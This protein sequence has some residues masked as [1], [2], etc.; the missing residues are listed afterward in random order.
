MPAKVA[1][2]FLYPV[3]EAPQD[4]TAAAGRRKQRGGL[5]LDNINVLGFGHRWVAS[6][7]QL[8]YLTGSNGIGGVRHVLQQRQ[9]AQA[10]HQLKRPGVYEV[11]H[12]HTGCIAKFGVGGGTAPAQ[13]GE[14]HDVV[15]QQRGGMDEFNHGCE[16]D[17]VRAD[18]IEGTCGQQ[19][20]QGP[21]ALTAGINDVMANIFDH[22]HIGAKLFNNEFVNLLEFV[23]HAGSDGCDHGG[24]SKA[25]VIIGSCRSPRYGSLGYFG[26][27]WQ[28]T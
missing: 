14:V 5:A 9:I 17:V 25:G 23:C 10:D 20:Q 22:R 3:V 16:L 1:H 26:G 24:L 19:D 13:G 21:E 11:T 8:Q 18:V 2:L 12:Q 28:G 7:H 15:V 27:C 4:G 6:S